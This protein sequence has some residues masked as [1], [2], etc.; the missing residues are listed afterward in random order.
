M[1]VDN[2]APDDVE[3]QAR[4]FSAALV[5]KNG[6]NTRSRFSSGI[7][8]PSSQNSMRTM[9]SPSRA[10]RTVRVPAP[11]MA[12]MTLSMRLVHTWFQIAWVAQDF[13]Q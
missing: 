5:V 9:L 4:T 13:G 2:H 7:P 1:L 10:V 12:S 11:P 8:H 6:E 3:A